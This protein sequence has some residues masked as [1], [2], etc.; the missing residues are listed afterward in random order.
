M[1]TLR[2]AASSEDLEVAFGNAIAVGAM[3]RESP[4]KVDYWGR[5]EL[6][7]H[8]AVDGADVFWNDLSGQ[9]LLV[10]RIDE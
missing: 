3:T 6:L 10:E 9:F 8:D 7:A 4:D 1:T 5:F 2:F